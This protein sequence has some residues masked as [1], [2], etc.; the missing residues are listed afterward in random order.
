[1]NVQSAE[2]TLVD[3][4]FALCDYYLSE[5]ITEHSRHVYDIYKLLYVV[6]INDDLRAL[7]KIVREERKSNKTCRSAQDDVDVNALLQEII[8]KSAY[9]ADYEEITKALLFEKVEYETALEALHRIIESSL[10]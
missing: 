2:R 6:T 1:M 7:A 8:D 4:L 5:K 10:F 9:K 3:K